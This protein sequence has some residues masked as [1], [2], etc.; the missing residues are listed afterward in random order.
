MNQR[1]KIATQ[2]AEVLADDDEH[3]IGGYRGIDRV[4]SGAE[5]SV[6]GVGGQTVDSRGHGP[7]GSD[8]NGRNG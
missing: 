8:L 1:E 6:G 2:T 5:H 4:T 7:L 3:R